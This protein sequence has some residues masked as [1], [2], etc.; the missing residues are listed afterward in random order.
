MGARR[1]LL[2]AAAA[3]GL[4]A[5]SAAHQRVGPTRTVEGEAWCDTPAPC[6]VRAL[7]A[8]FRPAYLVDDPQVSVPNSVSLGEDDFRPAAFAADL[9]F[10]LGVA[11]LTARLVQAGRGGGPRRG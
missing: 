2:L 9:L 1:H 10:F 8:G 3:L 5:A 6:E 11:H 4:T 7:W